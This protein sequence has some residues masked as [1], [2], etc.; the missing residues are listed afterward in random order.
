MSNAAIKKMSRFMDF[1]MFSRAN[2][3]VTENYAIPK[4]YEREAEE[5]KEAR[6]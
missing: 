4:I 5:Y 2:V 1:G 6:C 3:T